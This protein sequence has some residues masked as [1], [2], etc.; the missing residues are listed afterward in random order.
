MVGEVTPSQQLRRPPWC[1][2]GATTWQKAVLLQPRQKREIYLKRPLLQGV[3]AHPSGEGCLD[4]K[5]QGLVATEAPRFQTPRAGC[6]FDVSS[7][8]AQGPDPTK[9][10][11]SVYMFV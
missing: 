6:A 4:S 9:L 5:T 8:A 10:H 11:A 2:V 7:S 3:L 1:C